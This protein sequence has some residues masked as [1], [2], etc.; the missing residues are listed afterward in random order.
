MNPIQA[1]LSGFRNYANFEG[2]AS[3][4]EYWW[5]YGFFVV[6]LIAIFV[7]SV[8]WYPALFSLW[9]LYIAAMLL[10]LLAVTVRRLHDVDRP[11]TWAALALIPFAGVRLTRLLVQPGTP[12]PN[13]YGPVPL[14]PEPG[15][16]RSRRQPGPPLRRRKR[17]RL[18]SP[19]PPPQAAAPAVGGNGGRMLSSVPTA[20]LPCDDRGFPFFSSSEL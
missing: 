2:R 3:R 17:G 4:S 5:F 7:V 1:I 12:G 8:G 14:R 16:N 9:G 11:G 20:A 13:R 10:P 6:W 19:N 15:S 18:K